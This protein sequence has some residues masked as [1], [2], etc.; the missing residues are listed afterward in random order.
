M[1]VYIRIYL[2]IYIHI[3]KLVRQTPLQR[4]LVQFCKGLIS[5]TVRDIAM[6]PK[7][8]V[9]GPLDGVVGC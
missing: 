4:H 8:L 2:S 7:G 9:K 1:Y 3:P 6:K 5:K